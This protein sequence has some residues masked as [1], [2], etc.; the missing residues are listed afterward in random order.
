[1]LTPV[2]LQ[3]VEL[4]QS[5]DRIGILDDDD[6]DSDDDAFDLQP[7]NEEDGGDANRLSEENEDYDFETEDLNANE[8]VIK[9]GVYRKTHS[10]VKSLTVCT[11]DE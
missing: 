4:A 5:I 7:D 8:L 2:D 1:M 6:I 3:E 11:I 10:T 9:L